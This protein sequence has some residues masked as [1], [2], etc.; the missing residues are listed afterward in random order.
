M[1]T[2]FGSS[3]RP[4]VIFSIVV[5]N[6]AVH[7]FRLG[8]HLQGDWYNLYYSY[9][10]DFALPFTG[11]Y[12]LCLQEIYLPVLRRWEA[13]SAIVFLTPSIAETCQYFGIPVLG[14]TFD[15]F[16]YIVYG[17]GALSAAVVDVQVF[18][19]VFGFWAREKVGR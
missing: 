13:K 16:D 15:P 19:R 5:L 18:S 7:I 10:S 2:I 12:L 3:K 1:N 14:V 9:F 8:S 11:Y 6:A 17:I 4:A